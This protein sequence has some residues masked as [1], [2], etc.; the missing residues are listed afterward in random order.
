[1][2]RPV[3]VH[4]LDPQAAQPNCSRSDSLS[5]LEAGVA[6]RIS[7]QGDAALGPNDGLAGASCAAGKA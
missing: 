2:W 7:R 5:K 6:E 1:M 3:F 4:E